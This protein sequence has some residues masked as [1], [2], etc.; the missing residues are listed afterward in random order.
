MCCSTRFS[1]AVPL[2]NISAKSVVQAL[3]KFFTTFGLPQEIQSDRG[4]NFLSKVFAQVMKTLDRKH[5]Q[6]SAYHPESQGA[7][8]RFHQTLERMLRASCME[9][10]KPWDECLPYVMF[11]AREA[12]Q[13]S[14][15]FSP[16]DLVHAHTVKGPLKVLEE[17]WKNESSLN[18]KNVLAYVME[19]RERLHAVRK[20]AQEHFIEAQGEM[21]NY[22]DRQAVERT[23]HVVDKVLALLPLTD[24]PLKAKYHGPY[25]V[26]RKL[27]DSDYETA[28]PDRR[29]STQTCH[30]NMLRR[31]LEPPGSSEQ[32]EKQKPEADEMESSL[33]EY[34][35][36]IRHVRGTDNVL[37][38]G[39]SR[40]T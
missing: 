34:P 1:E 9:N 19:M 18:A 25:V 24:S 5:F 13:S 22:F 32:N 10:E 28:T 17:N 35:L 33:Q 40:M 36:I 26:T 20:L 23:F 11:A 39:L 12:K 38:D 6:S 31:Y 27:S 29:E 37:A 21:K 4:S 2:R 7:L 15:G 3:V 8:E 14:L 16:F 30:I